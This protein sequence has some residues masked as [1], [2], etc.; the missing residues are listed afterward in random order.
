MV[1]H[2]SEQFIDSNEQASRV[3]GNKKQQLVHNLRL[4]KVAGNVTNLLH[5]PQQFQLNDLTL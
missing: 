3:I 2:K 5:H 1:N 4:S